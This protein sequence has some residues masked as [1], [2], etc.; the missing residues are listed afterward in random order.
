MITRNFYLLLMGLLLSGFA[1]CKKT[2]VPVSPP[3]NV[4]VT[5]KDPPSGA[6]DGVS[7]INGGRSAIFNLYAPGKKSVYLIGDF[8]NWQAVSRYAMTN[9]TD[10]SRWWI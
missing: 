3:G 10:S 1:G 7:F 5:R 2:S 8:N 4:A 6:T 9:S